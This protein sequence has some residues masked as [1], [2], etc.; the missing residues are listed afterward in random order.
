MPKLTVLSGNIGSGKSTLAQKMVEESGNSIRLNRDSLRKMLFNSK[1]TRERE[2]LVIKLEKEMAILAFKQGYNVLIDDLNLS[3]HTIDVWKNLPIGPRKFEIIKIDTPLN[4]CIERDLKRKG[5]ELIG[6]GV[7]TFNA[8]K[9]S[10]IKLEDKP[11]ILVDVDGTLAN[12]NHRLK[13]V[14]DKPKDWYNFFLNAPDD[15]PNEIIVNWVN[16]L[17]N[18]NIIII[19][20]GR[21]TSFKDIKGD[22]ILWE[23]LN[24]HQIPFD[25]LLMRQSND[26][27]PDDQTKKDLL[28]LLPKEQIAFVIDD[29]LSV[30]KMWNQQG[31]KVY[32]VSEN[33]GN[34]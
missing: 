4:E 27:R 34:Y 10:L 11:I 17:K 18:D 5:V 13:F 33:D 31:L 16:E 2:E 29:R 9:Y 8:F 21:S 3:E 19:C 14:K 26:K 12:I 1:W 7:I 22:V 25:Y 15:T 6:P 28:A 24:K 30:C 20:S 23:W 32:Q